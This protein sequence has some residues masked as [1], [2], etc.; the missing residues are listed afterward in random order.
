MS[1]KSSSAATLH[2]ALICSTF[3]SALAAPS[4][5]IQL[6]NLDTPYRNY[7]K[8]AS[9]KIYSDLANA[10]AGELNMKRCGCTVSIDGEKNSIIFH[11]IFNKADYPKMNLS[12]MSI[13]QLA[14]VDYYL[15]Y[16]GTIRSWASMLAMKQ[17]SFDA[18][19]AISKMDL[20]VA[21]HSQDADDTM[22]MMG[23]EMGAGYG[24]FGQAY[25]TDGQLDLT[26]I[27]DVY[28]QDGMLKVYPAKDMAGKYT[29]AAK[30]R[31]FLGLPY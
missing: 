31:K 10:K 17:N 27:G 11:A 9:S 3:G 7:F 18:A 16:S 5:N 15:Y 24:F 1:R 28:E 21:L 19:Q 6:N 22:V 13:A 2:L 20:I 23:D 12:G 4:V 29:I 30:A 14:Y 26:P 25:Y 8:S